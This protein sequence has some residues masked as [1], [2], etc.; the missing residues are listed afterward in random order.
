MDRKLNRNAILEAAANMA[1]ERGAQALSIKSLAEQLG[2]KPPS[3]YK[4]FT[5]GLDEINTELML[6][7]W[8]LM[9]KSVIESAVGRSG[10]D[11]VM[12]ICQSYRSFAREHKGL[13][14][15][16]QWYNMYQS[17]EHLKAAEGMVNVMMRV[18]DAYD[19]ETEEKVHI[20]RMV[21][22]FLHGFAM[23]E[24]HSVYGSPF[25][26]DDTF[27]FSM[28]TIINGIS[29]ISKTAPQKEKQ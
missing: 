9:E 22:S 26:V 1:D 4:H 6:Y 16:M 27:E 8:G 2:I 25:S 10:D 17:E 5:G 11:A 21:R 23:L 19:V 29:D 14:E 13:Y 3:L 28:R 24:A 15:I 20:V 12:A 18:L 7:G